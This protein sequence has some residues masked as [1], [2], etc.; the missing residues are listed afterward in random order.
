M[1]K[2]LRF[3]TGGAPSSSNR[4]MPKAKAVPKRAPF[5]SSP[6]K[7]R[8]LQLTVLDDILPEIMKEEKDDLDILPFTYIYV[9]WLYREADEDSKRAWER[10]AHGTVERLRAVQ[11][12]LVEIQ[13]QKAFRRMALNYLKPDATVEERLL[14]VV[15]FIWGMALLWQIPDP[16]VVSNQMGFDCRNHKTYIREAAMVMRQKLNT[17]GMPMTMDP[18]AGIRI[19]TLD[20]TEPPADEVEQHVETPRVETPSAPAASTFQPFTGTSGRIGSPQVSPKPH[21]EGEE[22]STSSSPPPAPRTRSSRWT[23]PA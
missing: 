11:H 7:F 19:R 23:R 1:G 3:N 2:K 20:E 14:R 8:Y 17:M 4:N 16:P 13:M 15:S 22:S 18:T 9:N 10:G 12:P 21:K 5:S 6:D